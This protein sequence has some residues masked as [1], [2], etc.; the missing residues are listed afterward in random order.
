[1]FLRRNR[2]ARELLAGRSGKMVQVRTDASGQLDELVA[3]YP[4]RSVA[5]LTTH[6]TRLRVTRR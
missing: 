6:F 3:R 2:V 5:Q 4:A 1:M